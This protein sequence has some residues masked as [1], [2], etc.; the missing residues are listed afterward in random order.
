MPLLMGSGRQL[1]HRLGHI[2]PSLV[3]T[4]ICRLR[5]VN[6][7]N[8]ILL[9][10]LNIWTPTQVISLSFGQMQP[11][12][13]NLVFVA[14]IRSVDSMWYS[15]GIMSSK[16]LSIFCIWASWL[17]VS[18]LKSVWYDV[19]ISFRGCISCIVVSSEV[20]IYCMKQALCGDDNTKLLVSSVII[21]T[22]DYP[23]ELTVA[24]SI[25][26]HASVLFSDYF[27]AKHA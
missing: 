10:V 23:L 16:S 20:S 21:N 7:Q 1:D 8:K 9:D 13:T 17:H 19:G 12:S 5:T 6:F 26:F 18:S 27:T 15:L 24:N 25:I 11:C 14:V 4:H 3:E 2:F 22:S